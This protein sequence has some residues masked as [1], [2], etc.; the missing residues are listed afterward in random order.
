VKNVDW[1]ADE[2][3][4]PKRAGPDPSGRDRRSSSYFTMGVVMSVVISAAES[5]RM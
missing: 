3:G 4:W 5:A 2:G 1:L